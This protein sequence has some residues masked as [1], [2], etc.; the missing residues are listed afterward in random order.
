MKKIIFSFFALLMMVS[1][2]M[3]AQVAY[4]INENNAQKISISFL[5]GDLKTTNIQTDA[6][7]FSRIYLEGCG[8][9]NDV[10]NPELPVLVNTLEIPI[11][12]DYVL[13]IYGKDFVIYDA[14]TLGINHPI[15]PA[16]PPRSKSHQGKVEFFQNK[17][18]YQ[19]DAFFALPLAKFEEVGIMRNVN[20]GQLYVSPVQYNPV[21]Q[22]IKVYKSIDVEILFK[23]VEFVKTQIIKELHKSPL[24]QPSNIINLV[25]NSRAE[26]SNTPVKY[27]IV[28]HQLFKGALD[29]F[30]AW[31]KRKGFM[32]E[33]A[34]TDDPNVGTTTTTI[35]TYIKSHYTNATPENPAPTY[36]LLVGDVQQIPAF[37]V[38]T[39]D[40]HPTDLY[41]F[42]WNGGNLPCCYYGRFSAQNL[43]H[44]TPQ[45][46]KT[47]QYEQFTMPDPSYL[48]NICLIA[49]HDGAPDYCG[50]TYGNGFVNYMTQNYATTAYGYTNVYAH[51]DNCSGQAALIRQE[52]GNGVGIA[53]YTAHCDWNEWSDPVFKISHISAMNNANKYGL[54]I[55]NCCLSNKFDS[56]ECFG[57]AL[58]RA[59]NKG[60][61]GYI[62][63][64]DYTY[65]DE[66]YYWAIG[67]RSYSQTT[68]NPTYDATRLGSYDRLFHTHGEPKDKWMTTFG[69]M[70]KAGNEAVQQSSTGSSYKKYYWEIYH[71]MGDP[72]LMTYLTQPSP[73]VVELPNELIVGEST[74]TAKAAPYAYCA[75]TNTEG[76]LVG[77]GFADEEGNITLTINTLEVGVYEF[78]AWAQK[79]IQYFK[80]IQCIEQEGSF[81]TGGFELSSESTLINAGLIAFNVLLKNIGLDESAEI[82]V[83][84]STESEDVMINDTL[85]F[86]PPIEA[87]GEFASSKFL[88]AEING[89]VPDETKVIFTFNVISDYNSFHQEIEVAI[90]APKLIIT[91]AKVKNVS[92]ADTIRAG[93]E[94]DV[95]FTV[96]N[97]GHNVISDVL[98][99]V[100]ATE[101]F[102][103]E[104][105]QQTIA[106]IQ[107]D[108]NEKVTFRFKVG[109]SLTKDTIIPVL[110]H[111]FKGGYEA[112]SSVAVTIDSI[113]VIEDGVAMNKTGFCF[114]HPNP[115]HSMITIETKN[116]ILSYEIID[117]TGS[118]VVSKQNVNNRSTKVNVTSLAKGFYF[119]KVMDD[120][121]Q[122]AVR[123]FVKE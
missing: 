46:T 103:F 74:L 5:F 31:K 27:L 55:G 110:F 49:G 29:E 25:E 88:I 112:E 109:D 8:N 59:A 73:M 50:Q 80:T 38:T 81:I 98:A 53:N 2:S 62:G 70:I 63:G 12:G 89:N 54:M 64:S 16:Q 75:L 60:A 123:K 33:V 37:Q 1:I 108:E 10:G 58:L 18:T 121:Q 30:I 13:N 92:G 87:G 40:P 84:F 15:Y 101:D 78:A 44:L 102:E 77:A 113:P 68:A 7:I 34:Y 90:Q 9:S 105:V 119:I 32:V 111:A 24:F 99:E 76:E 71:L 83:A 96:S 21:T 116:P 66:D 20:L 93:D 11:F 114:I 65:W 4:K 14:K 39:L 6:G 122:T 72:S 117:L 67:A 28:A 91:G 43:T 86:I 85:A 107:A 97:I 69:S 26:F 100:S 106:E 118:V 95:E 52:I 48:D 51:L 94:V 3:N 47:L 115:A 61:V 19:T 56:G 42:T 36:V 23:K 45:I 82:K 17:N 120:K 79:Y 22:E 57:E 35:A 41:Y 104:N